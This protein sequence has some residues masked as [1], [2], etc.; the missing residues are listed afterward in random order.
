MLYMPFIRSMAPA[1]KSK[2]AEPKAKAAA[3][4]RAKNAQDPPAAKRAKK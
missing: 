2:D 4:K 3:E 1:E